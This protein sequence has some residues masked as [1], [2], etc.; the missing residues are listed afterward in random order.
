MHSREKRPAELLAYLLRCI[1]SYLTC[2]LLHSLTYM[3]QPP[4]LS[5]LSRTSLFGTHSSSHPINHLHPTLSTLFLPT[6]RQPNIHSLPSPVTMVAPKSKDA[7]PSGSKPARG[8]DAAAHEA[9]LLCVIDEIKGG[10]V[11]L[12]EVTRRMQERGYRY[13]YDAIKYL[14]GFSPLFAL[15][16]LNKASQF[17][18]CSVFLQRKP[19]EIVCFANILRLLLL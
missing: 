1:H 18:F 6:I 9:L 11:F 19:K 8:W 5:I 10:K 2:A 3:H 7:T 15:L 4:A 12:T 16:L 14:Q 17:V 13:S